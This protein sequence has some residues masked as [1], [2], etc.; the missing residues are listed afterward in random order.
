[1]RPAAQPSGPGRGRLA[2]NQQYP[3]ILLYSAWRGKWAH[4]PCIVN[5]RIIFCLAGKAET[6]LQRKRPFASCDCASG[7]LFPPRRPVQRCT[8]SGGLSLQ[9]KDLQ[10]PLSSVKHGE[11]EGE[12]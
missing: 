10:R 7:I 11:R 3:D 8:S 6:V 5:E 1:M 9:S 12:S 2:T 4:S